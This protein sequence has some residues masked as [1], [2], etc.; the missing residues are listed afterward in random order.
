MLT[1]TGTG[2]SRRADL[3][4]LA[5]WFHSADSDSAHRL[6]D[7]AFGCYPARH[8]LFG[9][10][11]PDTAT[12]PGTSWWESVPVNVP[13]SLMTYTSAPLAGCA[14][15]CWRTERKVSSAHPA[16]AAASWTQLISRKPVAAPM[17]P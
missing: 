16:S 11:E 2:L 8:L 17:K 4:K 15:Q 9:P 5:A 12:G 10:D 1:A 7:A 13:V 6:Y 14:D 3:L